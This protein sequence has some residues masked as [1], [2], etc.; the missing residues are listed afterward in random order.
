MVHA[1]AH[2]M[3]STYNDWANGTRLV[4]H[5]WS[6]PLV[7][8]HSRDLSVVS[9]FQSTAIMD[10]PKSQYMPGRAWATSRQVSS[11]QEGAHSKATRMKAVTW[12]TSHDAHYL[13]KAS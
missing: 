7:M 1:G 6:A 5:L 3:S 9:G 10:A 12:T 13:K 4:N 8:L 11:L 2:T